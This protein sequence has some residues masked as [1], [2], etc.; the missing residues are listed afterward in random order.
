MKVI[1]CDAK[2]MRAPWSQLLTQSDDEC[3]FNDPLVTTPHTLPQ[4]NSG[5]DHRD[6]LPHHIR[7]HLQQ[8]RIR[9]LAQSLEPDAK[10]LRLDAGKRAVL[11]L[12]HDVSLGPKNSQP[13]RAFKPSGECANVLLTGG[14][15]SKE[16]D[17]DRLSKS[18]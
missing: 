7:T 18:Q 8:S 10:R 17:Y 5:H 3:Q 12:A 2:M 16:V 4:R 13:L 1:C 11:M 6:D 14:A 15:T 9:K